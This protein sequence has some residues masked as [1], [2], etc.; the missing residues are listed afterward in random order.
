M[1]KRADSEK[2]QGEAD[3]ID[4]GRM[5]ENTHRVNRHAERPALPGTQQQ[6]GNPDEPPRKKHKG[7]FNMTA[8][9]DGPISEYVH[10][11]REEARIEAI[12]DLTAENDTNNGNDDDDEI[13]VVR[14]VDTRTD[15]P[16]REV[17]LGMIDAQ[18]HA[19][20]VPSAGLSTANRALANIK[21]ARWPA[22]KITLRRPPSG[23]NRII[24]TID[25]QNNR[26]GNLDLKVAD[27][28]VNLMNPASLAVNKM[29][30]VAML[31]ERPRHPDEKPGD[32]ISTLLPA[33][34]T[35][36]ASS[37]TV[38]S[39]GRV[40]SQ[41]QLFLRNPIMTEGKE[42][43]NP[44]VPK[45]YGRVNP[46]AAQPA[47]VTM[48]FNARTNEEI[49]RDVFSILDKMT[50]VENL[51]SLEPNY[52]IINK[53]LM[54]HQKQAVWFLT[55][56]EKTTEQLNG[57]PPD[58]WKV[59]Y[60]KD[61]SEIFYN[62]I[63]GDETRKIED[64]IMM[65]GIFADMMGLGK[66]LSTLA[67]FSVTLEDAREWASATP[68]KVPKGSTAERKARGTLIV[69]PTSVLSNW[70]EQINVHLI[71]GQITVYQYHGPKREQNLEELAKYDIVI[72]T[73]N[74]VAT[75]ASRNSRFKALGRLHWHRI[76]LD[77][78][79]MIR[80]QTTSTFTGCCALNGDRRW[81]VTGTPVQNRLEDLGALVKFIKMPPFFAQGSFEQHFIAPFKHASDG[82]V[83]SNLRLLVDSI[84]LRRSKD[85]ID[86]PKKREYTQVLDFSDEER[87]LYESFARDSHKK[88]NA[89]LGTNGMRGK[90]YAH[91]LT[92]ITRLRLLCAHGR[93]LLSE[94][95]Y[96]SLE[97]SSISSAIDLGDD[98]DD[99][100]KPAINEQDAYKTYSMLRET[101]M[102]QCS[103]CGEVIDKDVSE[104][105]DFEDDEIDD[106]IGYITPCYH[107]ICPK[108]IDAFNLQME[109]EK[110]PD[111][112]VECPTCP[113][114]IKAF[115][116]PLTRSGDAAEQARRDELRKNPKT[117]AANYGGPHTKVKALLQQLEIAAQETAA[118]P[119]GE[120]PV[121]TVVFSGWTSYLD[122]VEIALENANIGF[123]RLDGKMH[124]S[125]RTRVL[126]Q[127]RTDPNITVILVSIR[128][129]G[130]G[131]NFTA[132]S[133]CVVLEPQFNPAA[134]LQAIDR[135]HRLGQ[136]RDVEII[137]LIMADSFEENIVKLQKQKLDL[138]AT[139]FA[140]GKMS[141]QMEAKERMESLRSLF[142]RR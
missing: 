112:R 136:K 82:Q 93:E 98:E 5:I 47:R 33:R 85:K 63:S 128:A 66:T 72:T 89:I 78:A 131:L 13:T 4:Y 26:F 129:G 27:A 123:L 117:R 137:K 101:N 55:E 40:L 15:D 57:N 20:R 86:L 130:Q 60:A 9:K 133:K 132:A 113:Q 84:T 52:S 22:A 29:R 73:Y 76:V 21:G 115:T 103:A 94:D 119:P 139:A 106:V 124:V 28:L 46:P 100:D 102:T 92:F 61:R 49:S 59:K 99:D 90:A 42:V 51:P 142:Q 14:S 58:L 32:H 134:E 44:H 16:A 105:S 127:F 77:E 7:A 3:G 30:A 138:A 116:F 68:T 125:A 67:R 120:P 45:V 83:L 108:D 114:Y 56:H 65:G 35:I 2:P 88:L 54:A 17:C 39:I 122:L 12:V 140:N 95:D 74:I 36:F 110:G 37:K 18:I 38:D 69:C 34:I 8:N 135:I 11:K 1:L 87:T 41:R 48:T 80:N 121:R 43:I 53:E 91:M 19:D 104:E 81:A 126:E 6:N 50:N 23:Q 75:E 111:N 70:V 118:L 31:A 141:K 97:G 62:V 96:R 10:K 79:H 25:R 64:T 24:E 107:L 71:A 109:Q